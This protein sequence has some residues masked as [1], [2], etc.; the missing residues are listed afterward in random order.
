M[1]AI[2]ST[3]LSVM[4]EAISQLLP[5]TCSILTVTRTPDG[6]GGQTET[7]GT[8][9]A[10]CRLDVISG[11]ETVV[12]GAVQPYVRT[13][14]SLPYDTTI[15]EANRVVHGGVTYAVVTPPNSDQSWIAVKRVTLER[16]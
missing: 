13:M 16:I 9:S 10:S 15:T 2:D 8:T 7:Y 5:D 4:R 3:M 12:G 11:M 1:P 14:L 6:M